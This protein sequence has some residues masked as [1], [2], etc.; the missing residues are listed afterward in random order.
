MCECTGG[1][2]LSSAYN[3]LDPSAGDEFFECNVPPTSALP[4]S[5]DVQ[6]EWVVQTSTQA[7]ALA[8]AVHCSGG[9]F[10]V[11]W[12]GSV[13]VGEPIYVSGGTFLSIT[14]DGAGAVIDGNETTRLFT[15]VNAT[16]HL[17][18]LNVSQ[19]ASIIGGAIAAASSS[20]ELNKTNFIG[21]VATGHGGGVYVS[22]GSMVSCVGGGIFADNGASIDGGAM[23][24]TGGSV[25]SCGGSWF[26]NYAGDTGGALVLYEGS[27][28]SWDDKA[29]FA[30]NVA[31]R[32]G[33][34]AGLSNGSNVSW[35]TETIFDSNSAGVFGGALAILSTSTASWSGA[36]SY[37]NNTVGDVGYGGALYVSNSTASW[38]AST[39]FLRNKAGYQGGAVFVV[40][41]SILSWRGVDTLFEGNQAG[42]WGGAVMVSAA[43][44]VFCAAES[45]TAFCNNA[46]VLLGGAV[47]VESDSS[48]VFDGNLSFDAN[49]GPSGGAVFITNGSYLSLNGD[50]K[51]SSNEAIADGGV[52]GSSALDSASN[53]QNSTLIINGPTIFCNNTCGA[54][55]GALAMLGGLSIQTGMADVVFSHNTA[56]VAAVPCLSLALGLARRSSMSGL[57][58]I[59]L[60]SGALSPP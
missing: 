51:F 39:V 54:N 50:T 22:A 53:P 25:V 3:C 40:L 23:F 9:A 15:V 35:V 14:G 8:A 36:T 20:V 58:L 47:F 17:N 33:G 11:E 13:I 59:L 6:R 10:E 44:Y 19:G 28:M 49:T 55:G 48:I 2:C 52:V 27:R 38:S 42:R 31:K 4:C 30:N 26:S 24:V 12:K 57:N 5:A 16:L 46:A 45:M 29:V 7:Q 32:T 37:E 21:N 60:R 34:A 43:S 18:S 56:A 1:G 41:H